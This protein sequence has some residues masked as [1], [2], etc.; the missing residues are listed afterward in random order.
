MRLDS[1]YFVRYIYI[2]VYIYKYTVA[3]I[4]HAFWT[5]HELKTCALLVLSLLKY[6]HIKVYFV[7]NMYKVSMI[8]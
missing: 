7:P 1:N 3:K 4:M 8:I 5:Q 2:Y 6:V